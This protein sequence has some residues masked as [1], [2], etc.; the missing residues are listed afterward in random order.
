[1]IS[2]TV[3][4]FNFIL[5]GFRKLSFAVTSIISNSHLRLVALQDDFFGADFL[6]SSF[7]MIKSEM[8]F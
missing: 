5:H 2:L 1:M 4:T 6:I 8:P 7:L 3:L